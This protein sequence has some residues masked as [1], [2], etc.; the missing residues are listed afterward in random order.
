MNSIKI[1]AEN[2]DSKSHIKEYKRKCNECKTVWHS[3]VSREEQL[4][5]N[6]KDNNC[7]QSVAACGM[8]GGNWLALGA[9]NQAKT[10]EQ[11]ITQEKDRLKKCPKCGSGNYT[12]TIVYYEK[13]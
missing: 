8:C 7:N 3:L 12:E 5:K 1:T 13:K 2:Y 11:I 9:S 10:N 4:D 6:L